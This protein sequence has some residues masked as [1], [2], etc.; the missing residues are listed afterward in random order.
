MNLPRVPTP[1]WLSSSAI[2]LVVLLLLI[3]T[4][5]I[6]VY[7][8]TLVFTNQRT[9]WAWI[10]E[11]GLVEWLTF[12]VL[13]LALGYAVVM[14]IA[15]KRTTERKAA[16]RFWLILAV[17]FL[18]GALEEISYGQRVF[19]IETPG[20][21][22]PYPSESED[23]FYN[24]QSEINLHNLVIHHHDM[25]ELLYGKIVSAA[26]FLYLVVVPILYRRSARF[27]RC[28]DRWGVPVIQNYQLVV[29]LALA[30][31][32]YAVRPWYHKVTELLELMGCFI[33]LIMIV[34]PLNEAALPKPGSL[35]ARPPRGAA[36]I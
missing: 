12:V 11:D 25:N 9:L 10:R 8:I 16:R 3:L 26:V 2:P 27:R 36:P 6:H 21:L 33:F 34:H 18:F 35:R 14:R 29:F 31:L 5:V 4:V 7:G 1:R 13:F 30:M 24:R 15:C 22:V 23:N 17:L 19:G 28:T 20:F 32:T